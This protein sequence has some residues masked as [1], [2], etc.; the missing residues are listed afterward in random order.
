[1]G[2]RDWSLATSSDSLFI[3]YVLPTTCHCPLSSSIKLLSVFKQ[4]HLFHTAVPCA[5]THTVFEVWPN[6][7]A[8]AHLRKPSWFFKPQL[9]VSYSLN[10]FFFIFFIIYVDPL[11]YLF[12]LSA[13]GLRCSARA[14]CGGFSCCGAWV[15]GTVF[16]SC[17]TW[18]QQLW[19]T[20][21]R[22]Q[23]HLLWGTGLVAPQH[24]GS[25]RTRAWTH[26]PWIGRQILNHCITREALNFTKF[27]RTGKIQVLQNPMDKQLQG[28]RLFKNNIK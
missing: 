14:Y 5:L 13:L 27:P 2:L 24:V 6:P 26:V 18:A 15:L 1:M 19:L 10:F 25:S 4:S 21:S 3:S 11:I 9:N 23:A 20:G 28:G 12:I 22:A 8:L 16:S 17:G 7:S